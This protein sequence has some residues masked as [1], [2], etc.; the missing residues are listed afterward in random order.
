[1]KTIRTCRRILLMNWLLRLLGR[2]PRS[3][4]P[5]SLAGLRRN[6]PCWCG[7]DRSYGR[8]HRR[9][10]RGR[11]RELGLNPDALSANPFL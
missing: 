7:S 11:L 4:Y 2:K 10:D 6:D 8:C 5:A 1:M 3:K 9:E